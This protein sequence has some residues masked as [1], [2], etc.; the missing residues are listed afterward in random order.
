[1]NFIWKS[2]IWDPQGNR[3]IC[4][5]LDFVLSPNQGVELF[6]VIFYYLFYSKKYGN[7]L[8]IDI[9]PVNL[10]IHFVFEESF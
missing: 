10:R 3:F 5:P 7:F 2:G 6:G 4:L 9:Q 1:M 8:F